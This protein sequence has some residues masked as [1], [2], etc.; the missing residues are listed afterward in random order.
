PKA[1]PASSSM[2]LA[3]CFATLTSIPSCSSRGRLSKGASNNSPADCH[4]ITKERC[5]GPLRRRSC[6]R[7]GMSKM[8]L[9][10]TLRM[11]RLG[12]PGSFSPCSRL[13]PFID[14][15]I[16]SENSKCPN[17]KFSF[18]A[19]DTSLRLCVKYRVTK[20]TFY[21]EAQS[22][23]QGAKQIETL[24][25]TFLNPGLV[26]ACYDQKLILVTSQTD[27]PVRL[28]PSFFYLRGHLLS[29]PAITQQARFRGVLETLP[30]LI[31]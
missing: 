16:F 11:P 1:L 26:S 24:L 19:L 31:V 21:A 2:K 7:S 4:S 20:N 29:S 17:E 25:E 5:G 6:R 10:W 23:S 22:E 9:R 15:R 28:P 8:D 13:I 3:Q 27:H 18:A 30:L 12:W 14:S